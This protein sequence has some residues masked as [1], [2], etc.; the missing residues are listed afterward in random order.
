MTFRTPLYLAALALA[1]PAPPALAESDAAP[2]AS[3]QAAAESVD[4]SPAPGPAGEDGTR[5]WDQARVTALAEELAR[6]LRELRQ[7]HRRE[8]RPALGMQR[9]HAELQ[10]DFRTMSMT[11]G[12][13]AGQLEDGASREET[14]PLVQRLQTL[15]RDAELRARGQHLTS[16]TA[17]PVSA[18]REMVARL[19][20]YYGVG[21]TLPASAATASVPA[22]PAER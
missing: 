10:D 18:A 13:L 3:A 7:A 5:P 12:R 16:S 20:P 17:E 21:E 8:P 1:L 9:S 6:S 2:A 22:A 19:E 11:A 15:A 14:L 4:A